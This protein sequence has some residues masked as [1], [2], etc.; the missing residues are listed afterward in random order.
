MA[1]VRSVRG[2]NAAE[3][4]TRPV[5]GYSKACQGAIAEPLRLQQGLPR[6]HNKVAWQRTV[7][8]LVKP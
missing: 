8:G 5:R 3:T 7:I 2:N 1:I 4:I 6:N